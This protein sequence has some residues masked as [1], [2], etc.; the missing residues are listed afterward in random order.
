MFTPSGLIH[1][2]LPHFNTAVFVSLASLTRHTLFNWHDQWTGSFRLVS[3]NQFISSFH[4]IF[5]SNIPAL[6]V[7][8]KPLRPKCRNL[9]LS[10]HNNRGVHYH[11]PACWMT[12]QKS[13]VSSFFLLPGIHKNIDDLKANVLKFSEL[14]VV[15][16]L[17]LGNWTFVNNNNNN[18]K[19]FGSFL[20]GSAS[21]FQMILSYWMI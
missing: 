16:Q 20:N 1:S 5:T 18:K 10:V 2:C 6:C 17:W 15:V 21:G 13:W 4:I 8:S 7:H 12:D 3:L 9:S 14:D 11:F 19:Y